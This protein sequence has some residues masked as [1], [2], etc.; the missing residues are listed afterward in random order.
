MHP[1]GRR[2]PEDLRALKTIPELV[3]L[4]ERYHQQ[5]GLS[6]FHGVMAITAGR[7]AKAVSGGEFFGSM[8]APWK[9]ATRI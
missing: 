7:P 2:P 5:A 4:F 8:I 1:R 6:H 9:E 3:G